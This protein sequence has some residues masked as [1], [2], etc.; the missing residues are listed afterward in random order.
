MYYIEAII[1]NLSNKYNH[2]WNNMIIVLSGNFEQVS[3]SQ[4]EL[5]CKLNYQIK[6]K[7]SKG[8]CE[9]K[10]H[11]V[12]TTMQQT[13]RN[14]QN[15]A[16]LAQGY[17]LRINYVKNSTKVSSCDLEQV[18]PTKYLNQKCI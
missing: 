1:F 13:R 10:R 8:K 11:K 2:P 6:P 12:M 3:A 9:T 7:S 14:R 4:T 5:W 15:N 18:T 16:W 17:E